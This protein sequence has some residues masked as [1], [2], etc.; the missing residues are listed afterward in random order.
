MVEVG[1]WNSVIHM[2]YVSSSEPYRK[3]VPYC[4]PVFSKTTTK[5]RS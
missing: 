3:S 2:N 1:Q 5:K 4:V